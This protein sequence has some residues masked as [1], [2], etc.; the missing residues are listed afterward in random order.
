MAVHILDM[1]S[2]HSTQQKQQTLEAIES[3]TTVLRYNNVMLKDVPFY[4]GQNNHR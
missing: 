3:T 1:H 2:V 4:N